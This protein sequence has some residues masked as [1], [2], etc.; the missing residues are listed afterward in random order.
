[1]S[2]YF[3]NVIF[4]AV[5]KCLYNVPFKTEHGEYNKQEPMFK[6]RGLGLTFDSGFSIKV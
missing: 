6:I 5:I 2:I 1:M 3:E 4:I